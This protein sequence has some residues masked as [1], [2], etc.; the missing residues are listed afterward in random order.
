MY[1]WAIFPTLGICWQFR[2]TVTSFGQLLV[3]QLNL[4]YQQLQ[5]LLLG[6]GIASRHSRNQGERLSS[7][8]YGNVSADSRRWWW[9]RWWW[10]VT[11]AE[12][13]KWMYNLKNHPSITLAVQSHILEFS[14][15]RSRVKIQIHIKWQKW[16]KPYLFL[17]HLMQM[18]YLTKFGRRTHIWVRGGNCKYSAFNA[19]WQDGIIRKSN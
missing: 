11:F 15:I 4:T 5:C 7:Q 9:H 17:I 6:E 16:T 10:G 13:F 3:T 8:S 2:A 14:I 18:E 19:P 12:K 1:L